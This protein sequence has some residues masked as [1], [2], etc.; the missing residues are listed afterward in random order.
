MLWKC[1]EAD[2]EQAEMGN[3]NNVFF[4]LAKP[5]W[6]RKKDRKNVSSLLQH[7]EEQET[8]MAMA[9]SEKRSQ[10]WLH[11]SKF[12]TIFVVQKCKT[13]QHI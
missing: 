13:G 11:L 12:D 7:V 6:V 4:S 10:L 3:F 8:H 1:Y 5:N 2:D 9:V